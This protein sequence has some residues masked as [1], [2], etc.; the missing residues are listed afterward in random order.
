LAKKKRKS[1]R[2]RVKSLDKNPTPYTTASSGKDPEK[3]GKKKE[4]EHKIRKE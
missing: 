2:H 4:R 1:R 3:N